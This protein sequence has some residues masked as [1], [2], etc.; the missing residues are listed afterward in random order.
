V[1]WELDNGWNEVKGKDWKQKVNSITMVRW[2]E[3]IDEQF[4]K[5]IRDWKFKWVRNNEE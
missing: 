2:T 3:H 4:G 1:G 5:R